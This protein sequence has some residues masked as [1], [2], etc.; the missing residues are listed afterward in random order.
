M[1]KLAFI[2]AVAL[3]PATAAGQQYKPWVSPDGSGAG[4]GAGAGDTARQT[5]IER[6]NSLVDEAEKARAADPRFLSDLRDLARGYERPWRNLVLADDFGDGDF[7]GNPRWTVTAGKYLVQRGWGLRSIVE[8]ERA[9]PEQR[10]LSGKEV[11][12][13]IFGQILQQAIAPE[14]ALGQSAAPGGVDAA[15]IQTGFPLTNAFA[16]EMDLSSWKPR[17]RLEIGPYQGTPEGGGW[18]AGYV[19]VYT[20]GGVWELLRVSA[21][22][23]SVIDSRSARMSLE[24]KKTH[25]IEWT[26]HDDGRMTVSIDGREI[27]KAT[28]R[29]VMTPFD[30]FR[31]V[32]RGGDYI[33]KRIQIFA[34]GKG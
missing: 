8:A 3:I 20:P 21:R 14:R 33:L 18:A 34:T 12:A 28:D 9:A 7:I 26:R 19:L 27:L 30:G 15:A 6:L 16:I 13:N 32:N 2:L 10:R 29:G 17:G 22:G 11:A 24:D 1:R 25:R 23:S 5:L 31:M 4:A